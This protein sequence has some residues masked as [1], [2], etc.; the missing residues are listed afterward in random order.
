MK[1]KLKNIFQSRAAL[2][3]LLLAFVWMSL[4]L[5]KAAY[6]KYQLEQQISTIKQEI[7]KTEQRS[8]ELNEMINYFSSYTYLEQ[9]AKEKL[10]L[11]KEGETV[12]V[13][14]EEAVGQTEE[15]IESPSPTPTSSPV[16][17]NLIK[18]WEFLFK[19]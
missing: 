3:L 17:N 15:A 5:V 16:K 14:P 19:K 1:D 7:E 12:V 18:W 10:N 13:V 4:V 11:K 6:K 8:K 9:E 2:F